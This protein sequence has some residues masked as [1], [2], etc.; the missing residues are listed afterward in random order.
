MKEAV[1]FCCDEVRKIAKVRCFSWN[2]TM[3]NYAITAAMDGTP[4]QTISKYAWEQS[5]HVLGCFDLQVLRTRLEKSGLTC[6][7]VQCCF[8]HCTG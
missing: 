2:V 1:A 4:I 6:E 7:Q 8:R 5:P 3:L